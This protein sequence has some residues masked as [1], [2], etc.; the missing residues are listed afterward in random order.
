MPRMPADFFQQ[1]YQIA[2]FFSIQGIGRF[3]QVAGMP[4]E[5]RRND[6]T[7]GFGQV[8]II[9]AP[10]RGVLDSLYVTRFFQSV[11]GSCH[12]AAAEQH[13]FTDLID[14]QGP[15]MQ[16]RLHD[17]EIREAQS[18]FADAF[19]IHPFHCLGRFPKYESYV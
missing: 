9:T 8:N 1:A 18:R 7:A 12:G 14:G 11:D 4:P 10:V 5:S 13:L 6:S 19:E 17:G 3:F 16:Q 15:L 2:A